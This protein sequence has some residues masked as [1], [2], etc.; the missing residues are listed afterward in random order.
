MFVGIV[1]VLLFY[2]LGLSLFRQT[3]IVH[4]LLHFIIRSNITDSTIIYNVPI[5]RYVIYLIMSPLPV[6]QVSI[7][8]AKA[9]F[10]SNCN[11]V[12]VQ[13]DV[14]NSSFIKSYYQ[15]IWSMEILQLYESIK[16]SLNFSQTCIIINHRIYWFLHCCTY[17]QSSYKFIHLS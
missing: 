11:T 2:L 5:N 12:Q 13:S 16:N 14:I 10:K 7:S 4:S 1:V 6:V 15:Q 17:F 8:S 3:F 9:L